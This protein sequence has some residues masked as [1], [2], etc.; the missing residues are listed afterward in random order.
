LLTNACR[1]AVERNDRGALAIPIL[2]PI[3]FLQCVALRQCDT[4]CGIERGKEGQRN[5][6]NSN[7]E[8]IQIKTILNRSLKSF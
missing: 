3:P 6:G 8:S 2:R 7:F 1:A 4:L 5:H